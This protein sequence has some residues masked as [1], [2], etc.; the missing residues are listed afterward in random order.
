MWLLSIWAE[1]Y[2]SAHPAVK[3]WPNFP[4][5]QIVDR[6]GRCLGVLP[7]LFPFDEPRTLTVSY[8]RTRGGYPRQITVRVENP[9]EGSSYKLPV[10]KWDA[11]QKQYLAAGATKEHKAEETVCP[12]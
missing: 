12:N 1:E 8:E 6:S 7:E 4:R 11:D 3:D 2:L 5:T 9:A 10:M